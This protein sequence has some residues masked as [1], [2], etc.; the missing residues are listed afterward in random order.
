MVCLERFFTTDVVSYRGDTLSPLLFVLATDFL[1]TLLNK[2][3]K[4]DLLDLPMA[5]LV[6]G[7]FPVIQY[8]DDTLLYQTSCPT[9]LSTLKDLLIGFAH[10]SRL[11]VNYQ[12]SIIV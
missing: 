10:D 11:K 6:Q 3:P 8:A 7:S 4:Y 2:V 12:K 9:Q 1:Q 5:E